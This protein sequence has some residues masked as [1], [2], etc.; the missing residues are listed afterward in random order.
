M[1]TEIEISALLKE[2]GIPAD[3]LGYRYLIFCVDEMIKDP[4][5]MYGMFKGIYPMVAAKFNTSIVRAERAIRNAIEVGWTRGNIETQNKLFGYTVDASK[6]RPT[7][8]EF[9][10]TVA[11]WLVMNQE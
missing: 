4:S 10:C 8:G 7:N 3:L 5:L 1:A 9:L 6:G 2:L 11:D